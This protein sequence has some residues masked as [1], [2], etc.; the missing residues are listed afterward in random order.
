MANQVTATGIETDS[1]TDLVASF[2]ASFETIYGADINLD[3]DSPDGQLMYIFLQVVVDLLDLITQVY[4]SFDPDYA[5]GRVLDQRVALNGIQRQAGT[6]STTPIS[7]TV[8][9]ALTLKGLDTFPDDPYTVSDNA[10]TQWFLEATHS[11][12]GSGTSSLSFRAAT[13]GAALTVVNTI[14]SPITIVL[15]VDSINNPLTQTSV[16]I[17]EETDAALKVRRLKSVSL[18][19]IGYLQGLLAALENINGVSSAF[20][21]ENT[22]DSPDGDGVPGHSI[23]VIVAGGTDAEIANVIYVKR[24]AGC[25]MFG[26]QSYEIVQVD[27]SS[28]TVYWDYVVAEN[29]YIKFNATSLNGID[30]PNTTLIADTLPTLFVPGV[31]EKVN[32]NDLATLVQ[33]IDPNTLVTGAGFSTAALGP[34][35][36]TLSPTLKKNQFAVATAR[37][38]ITIV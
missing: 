4:N 9:E 27:G 32:I 37:I 28:F 8:T 33:Q 15:G 34:F 18:S 13:P 36:N 12:V 22:D 23:W 30:P 31:N 6:F 1:L 17:N 25:G 5:I 14:T 20:V 16:G 7:I 29:L 38:D 11:F 10:G 21:Y 3:S 24:N 2:T 35:T 19:S 26:A